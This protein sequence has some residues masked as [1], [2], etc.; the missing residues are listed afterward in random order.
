MV[1]CG[2]RPA[3]SVSEIDAFIRKGRLDVIPFPPAA[4]SLA[5]EAFFKYGKG[6]GHPAQ[7]N[8]GDCISYAVSKLEMMP[9]LFKGEDF[10]LTDVEAAL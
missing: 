9:L 5:V 3:S 8:F 1:Y 4:S 10:R 7:L 2:R 6:R